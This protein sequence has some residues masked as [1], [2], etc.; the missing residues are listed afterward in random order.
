MKRVFSCWRIEPEK[1]VGRAGVGR[2]LA[3]ARPEST[4]QGEPIGSRLGLVEAV[5]L[6]TRP[7]PLIT[8]K[9]LEKHC[10][11][12]SGRRVTPFSLST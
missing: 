11:S 9:T 5:D 2:G 10:P 6:L 7:I 1:G 3:R 12:E 8:L 4:D